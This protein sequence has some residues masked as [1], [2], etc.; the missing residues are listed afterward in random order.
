MHL[1]WLFQIL[2]GPGPSWPPPYTRNISS[3][4]SVFIFRPFS[5]CCSLASLQS[6]VCRPLSVHLALCM[7][8]H[9]LTTLCKTA[10]LFPFFW[11]HRT[12]KAVWQDSR[13]GKSFEKISGAEW[14]TWASLSKLMSNLHSMLGLLNDC[15]SRM[16][17]IGI[18][19]KLEIGYCKKFLELSFSD[20]KK[21]LKKTKQMPKT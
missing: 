19:A 15:V 5:F 12:Y 17:G 7:S 3:N 11:V 20:L 4:K 10:A 9:F 18:K 8:P 1:F 6:P 13:K 2:V 16:W 14:K 21:G